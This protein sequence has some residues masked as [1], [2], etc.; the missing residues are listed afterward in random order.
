L[1]GVNVLHT[2]YAELHHRE[3]VMR[4]EPLEVYILDCFRE[5]GVTRLSLREILG[6]CT[7]NR[8]TALLEALTALESE[9]HMVERRTPTDTVELT[10]LGKRYIG[11]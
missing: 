8:Y 2:V 3:S 9:H 7:M 6:D 5:R 4:L 11:I 1:K 10:A